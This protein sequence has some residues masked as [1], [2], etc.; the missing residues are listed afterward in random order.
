LKTFL[1]KKYYLIIWAL[2]IGDRAWGMGERGIRRWGE[3][4][5]GRWGDREMGR[6]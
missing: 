6:N 2:G 5:M 4:E 1:T 3:G